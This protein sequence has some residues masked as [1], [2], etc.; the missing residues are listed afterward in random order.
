MAMNISAANLGI[1]PGA[2]AGGWTVARWGVDAIGWGN[3][4]LTPFAL[5]L[6]AV[7]A[8]GRYRRQDNVG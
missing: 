4:S 5:G 6:A 8:S 7:L 1:A 2:L 3:L